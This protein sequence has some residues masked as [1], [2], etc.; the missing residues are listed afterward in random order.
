MATYLIAPALALT[1]WLSDLWRRMFEFELPPIDYWSGLG[2]SSIRHVHPRL[3]KYYKM[4]APLTRAA[5]TIQAANRRMRLRR[6]WRERP[7]PTSIM[8]STTAWDHAATRTRRNYYND[9]GHWSWIY[10]NR[11]FGNVPLTMQ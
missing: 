4:P 9:A 2:E 1:V 5:R 11:T 10:R 6:Q 8:G 7:D 3:L